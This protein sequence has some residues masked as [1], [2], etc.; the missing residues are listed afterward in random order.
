MT[1]DTGNPFRKNDPLYES[2]RKVMETNELH[3]EVVSVVNEGLGI[4][5][6]KALPF[7]IQSDYDTLVKNVFESAQVDESVMKQIKYCSKTARRTLRKQ[8]HSDIHQ[9][10][11]N[12][13]GTEE[14]FNKVK[15]YLHS[16]GFL[17]APIS[18]ED[19]LDEASGYRRSISTA[20][21]GKL[22]RKIVSTADQGKPT[23]KNMKEDE[24]LDEL[25]RDTL[26]SYSKKAGNQ[27]DAAT[28][29]VQSGNNVDDT[30]DKKTISKR[31]KGMRQANARMEEEEQIDEAGFGAVF[32]A[33]RSKMGAG[34]TF[35]YNGKSY[36]T[37][38][39]DDSKMTAVAKDTPK[40]AAT[41]S[42]KPPQEIQGAQKPQKE[43]DGPP[44]PAA[45][46]TA[47][48][49]TPASLS[50]A[51]PAGIGQ[52]GNDASNFVR[53][54]LSMNEEVKPVT[55]KIV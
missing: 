23:P 36:S 40:P 16:I 27:A 48:V 11:F 12:S 32:A 43:P 28:W 26:K 20:D 51:R 46:K 4:E 41:S 3:R 1:F 31:Y 18:E 52:P 15:K 35:T 7:E 34:K 53:K 25:S 9:N 47:D 8:G 39:A 2:V 30:A 10:V 17:G 14:V 50:A 21:R 24:Q 19:E 54:Q 38:R 42:W 45:P 49:P 55:Y 44:V 29:R 22:T 5:D 37:N 13:P 6:R 33:A